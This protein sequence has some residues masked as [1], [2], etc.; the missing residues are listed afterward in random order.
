MLA[1][2]LGLEIGAY[3]HGV[4]SLHLYGRHLALAQRV[5]DE[6]LPTFAEMPRMEPVSELEAFLSAERA[7][8]LGGNAPPLS[9]YWDVLAR[10]LKDFS[11]SATRISRLSS[12]D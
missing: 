5:L 1:H 2:T 4:G 3:I 9:P 6:K 11:S 8:R 12:P 7:I 10:S